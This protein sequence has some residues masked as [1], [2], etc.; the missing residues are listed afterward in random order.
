MTAAGPFATLG[1]MLKIQT[2]RKRA[3]KVFFIALIAISLLF[4][5]AGCAKKEA[6]KSDPVSSGG[7]TS[8]PP[9]VE[10]AQ[11]GPGGAQPNLKDGP[12]VAMKPTVPAKSGAG[13]D[14]PPPPKPQAALSKDDPLFGM[15][16]VVVSASDFTLGA[17]QTP[18]KGN[19]K[20]REAYKLFSAFLA[21]LGEGGDAAALVHPDY[22]SFLLP[23]V[24]TVKT[25]GKT[26]ES[27]RIGEIRSNKDG[28]FEAGVLLF[29]KEGRTRGKILG[30]KREEI[31]YVSGL[32]VDF[33]RLGLVYKKEGDEVFLPMSGDSPFR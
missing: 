33:S 4:P 26:F 1:L 25:G 31:F 6:E 32:L 19:A 17:L 3:G 27:F 12:S 14:L 10:P 9:A 13:K 5:L 18:Y 22:R 30:E 8:V 7:T 15:P 2:T 20:E 21:K 23:L 24:E 16:G 11:P 28:V 29:G